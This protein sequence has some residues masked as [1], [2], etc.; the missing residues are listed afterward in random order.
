M[1][2]KA[3]LLGIMIS[4]GTWS[5]QELSQ[6][7]ENIELTPSMELLE[8]LGTFQD[9]SGHW[10]DPLLLLPVDDDKRALTQHDDEQGEAQTGETQDDE[11]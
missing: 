3:M 1:R 2:V 6:M 8:F 4:G 7:P 10:F 11:Y 9:R 5:E